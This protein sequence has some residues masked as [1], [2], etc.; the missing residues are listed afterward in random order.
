M[1]KIVFATLLITILNFANAQ[2]TLY[3]PFKADFAVGFASPS[4]SGAKAG[5]LFSIEPKYAITNK[6]VT[7]I[8]LEGAV[9]ARAT[10]DQT[11][12]MVSGEV[13][14]NA[15]YIVTTDYFYTTKKFRPFTG[16]GAGLFSTAAG[17]VDKT[18]GTLSSGNKF[19][20]ITRAGFEFGHFRFATEY[21]IVGKTGDI[22]NNYIGFKIGFF[23]GG[24]KK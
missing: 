23:A 6:I 13:K 5:V 24:A 12:Q 7:G 11:G 16:A 8:R 3:K 21:N 19:G 17:S 2:S 10:M 15:S 18:T 1:K 20:A 14:A 22:K 4:G 9:M